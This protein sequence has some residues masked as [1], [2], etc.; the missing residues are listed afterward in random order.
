MKMK[1]LS[2]VFSLSICLQLV[3]SPLPAIAADKEKK[4]TGAD[5]F[6]FASGVV[7]TAVQTY[8][9]MNGGNQMQNP[10]A[11]QDMAALGQQQ[12]P[13][14]DRYFNAQKLSNI[15]GLME[16]LALNGINPSAI[17]CT[18]LP[19]TLYEAQ[20]EV[21]RVGI[22]SDKGAPQ[23]QANEA[24]AYYDQYAKIEKLYKN[25]QSTSNV[26]G[27]GFGYGC[28]KRASEILN[29]FFQYRMNELEKMK[30]NLEAINN[31]FKEMSKMDLNAIEESTAVLNGEDT[32][33]GSK[34][35]SRRPDLFDYA[36]RFGN[37]ACNSML[38]P[39]S[40][41]KEGK[42]G[43]LLGLK[44]KITQ[45][46]SRPSGKFSAEKY[47]PQAHAEVEADIKKFSND[48]GKQIELNFTSI[49][50]GK[51]SVDQFRVGSINDIPLRPNLFVDADTKFQESK[52]QLDEEVRK[53]S[54]ELASAK[55][56]SNI[57]EMV[58]NPK[59]GGFTEELTTIENS[60]KNNCLSRNLAKNF[61]IFDPRRSK[62]SNKDTNDEILVQI[63]SILESDRSFT[64][65]MQDLKS[66][67]GI[68]DG[69]LQ[70]SITSD[71]TITSEGA[72]G[73]LT[74]VVKKAGIDTPD[75][76]VS[77]IM[78]HCDS[79]FAVNKLGNKL[80]GRDTIKKLKSLKSDFTD[81]SSKYASDVR[82]EV[83]KK[84]LNCSS[85]TEANASTIGTCTA[86]SFNISSGG[87]CAA[88]AKNC[89][90]NMKACQKIAQ[91]FVTKTTQERTVRVNNYKN[92]MQ[93]NKNDIVALF[94]GV[95]GKFIKEGEAM[96]SAF[97]AGFNAPV[98]IKRE[99]ADGEKGKFIDG[100]DNPRDPLELENPDAFVKMFSQNIDKLKIKVKEQQEQLLGGGGVDSV[101][102][103]LIG[104]HMEEVKA[105]Y[106]QVASEAATLANRCLAK[107]DDFVKSMDQANKQAQDDWSKKTGELN[108][109]TN[110]FCNKYRMAMN[111]SSPMCNGNVD[112][113][114][115]AVFSVANTE[116]A[117][118]ALSNMTALCTSANN[119]QTHGTEDNV[120]KDDVDAVCALKDLEQKVVNR[121]ENLKKAKAC[122]AKVKDLPGSTPAAKYDVY[123]EEIKKAPC[124][125]VDG[126][127]DLTESP[128]LGKDFKQEFVD[129]QV[130]SIILAYKS[131]KGN[132][133]ASGQTLALEN[134]KKAGMPTFCDANNNS[135][136]NNKGFMGSGNGFIDPSIF[137]GGR[138]AR[139][140]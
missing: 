118:V 40:I 107:H 39:D 86:E 106:S 16:Y 9:A 139:S 50:E 19:A 68:R 70:I 42:G 44:E 127:N 140:E 97:G 10:Q 12:T 30:T 116:E 99:I 121:C 84:L 104:K 122:F 24:Y 5:I 101:G 25:Y 125:E 112:D 8:G 126:A 14:P 55:V 13:V 1:N 21:C 15:P 109:K 72:N 129:K 124:S 94:D 138:N 76:Y 52:S 80:S 3:L 65:K 51:R 53:V 136:V 32:K 41:N 117:S 26:D 22:T 83:K 49:L 29:G 69:R 77:G 95:M 120:T 87:F 23:A 81:L 82:E 66:V 134:I 131:S 35:R 4:V 132:S 45:E 110:Q 54:T 103:G 34:V 20:N 135:N 73:E 64:Q 59:A 36:K 137:N 113:L 61:R 91:D 123:K 92:L 62:E 67:N 128:T 85:D 71:Y 17:N 11:S 119:E 130:S 108:D 133:A 56:P 31:R 78:K 2:P 79:Q 63:N 75:G 33:L 89:A 93:K 60:I 18:S 114:A 88:K 105:K 7:N 6:N 28:M 96:R 74:K 27:Q 48:L 38:S 111:S 90:T 43:G 100:F 46:Y 98:D 58:I 57:V 37:P 102:G 47:T 115:D